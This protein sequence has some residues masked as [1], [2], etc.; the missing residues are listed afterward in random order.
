VRGSSRLLRTGQQ[1]VVLFRET[2]AIVFDSQR[3]PLEATDSI[4]RADQLDGDVCSRSQFGKIVQV[5]FQNYFLA[6]LVTLLQIDRNQL[7]QCAHPKRVS[8][9]RQKGGQQN[10]ATVVLRM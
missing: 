2:L 5:T 1:R 10:F 4:F 8:G 9:R 3:F 6:T 7:V